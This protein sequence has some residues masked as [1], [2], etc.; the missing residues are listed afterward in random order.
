MEDEVI[1]LKKVGAFSI[2][3]VMGGFPA[4]GAFIWSLNVD[5]QKVKTDIAVQD[6]KMVTI[7]EHINEIK[8]DLKDIKTDIRYIRDRVK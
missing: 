4:L 2:L 7:K 6:Q 5:V 1:K 8:T 3:S